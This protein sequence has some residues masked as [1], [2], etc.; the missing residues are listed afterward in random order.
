MFQVKPW[1]ENLW[2]NTCF[3]TLMGALAWNAGLFRTT[4]RL[5]GCNMPL[6]EACI[7]Q[8]DA[9]LCVCISA[10]SFY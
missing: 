5:W 6:V 4:C 2:Q 8:C 9:F 1:P 10:G 7:Q 3:A